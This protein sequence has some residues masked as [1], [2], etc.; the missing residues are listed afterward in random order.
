MLNKVYK[1]HGC[2][3]LISNSVKL[4]LSESRSLLVSGVVVGPSAL[5][6]RAL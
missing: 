2:S 1:K 6:L 4:R 5:A 3:L